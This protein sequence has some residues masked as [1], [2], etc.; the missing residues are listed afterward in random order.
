MNFYGHI[1]PR[2]DGNTIEREMDRYL[3]LVRNGIAG[4]IVFGG[5]IEELRTCICRLQEEAEIP[6][7]MASDLEQGLGQQ[8]RGGTLFPP[9]RAITA[10]VLEEG[11]CDSEL[12]RRVFSCYAKEALYAGIN[13]ILAPVVD[14]NTNPDNPIIA[15]RSFG[16]DRETVSEMA[17]MMI[18]VFR[19]HGIRSC[20]KHFPGHGD[21]SIDS[22]L[23]L[24]VLNKSLAEMEKCELY[25]FREAVDAGVDAIML[26]HMAVP[27][28][29]SSGTPVSI[30]EEA[31]DYIRN[32]LKFDGIIMTDALDMG[33]LSGIGEE[34]A[35]LDALD[36]GVDILLHPSDAG[37]L[38]SFLSQHG[39]SRPPG[40]VKSFRSGLS[41]GSDEPFPAEV[42]ARVSM[43]VAVR[44]I[45]VPEDW[46]QVRPSM[47]CSIVE[48]KGL[49]AGKIETYFAHEHPG[50]ERIVI[51]NDRKSFP[52]ERGR[53][54]ITIVYSRTAA[55]KG[56]PPGWM[57]NAVVA[58]G[59][60]SQLVIVVGNPYIAKDLDVPS[61]KTYWYGEL[62]ETALIKKLDVLFNK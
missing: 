23:S 15:A 49:S 43:D 9:A 4:F 20:A 27:S 8:V 10:A 37:R 51:E 54:A 24:P 31:T 59:V 18:E 2:L 56:G 34:R 48:E 26:A 22:H 29:D 61:V 46:R 17:R 41:R 40:R 42:N 52:G 1:V 16:E 19:E 57:R 50:A 3:S 35:G 28:M 11:R 47:I 38:A 60:F 45:T 36:A 44:A 12:V 32:V 33:G 53:D 13:T 58:A 55:W 21:T 5:E 14:I 62:A 30:S 7:I 6:L 25:P 39:S